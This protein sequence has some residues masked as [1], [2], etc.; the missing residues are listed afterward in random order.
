[1]ALIDYAGIAGPHQGNRDSKGV[2]YKPNLGVLLSIA[3][4]IQSGAP[5]RIFGAPRVKPAQISDGLSHTM[6]VGELTG[7]AWERTPE[8]VG[9]NVPNGGWAY[10]TNVISIRYG[11]NLMDKYG[12]PAAWSDPDQLYSDHP[13]GAHVLY[14]DGS[15][16]YLLEDTDLK[17][18]IALATRNG[19][20]I[21]PGSLAD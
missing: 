9:R 7:R 2:F 15:V 19:A 18:L 10:G 3:P 5:P 6:V 16:H 8:G 17:L 21:L 4:L 12:R 20:E 1:M 13:G 11:I 14:C